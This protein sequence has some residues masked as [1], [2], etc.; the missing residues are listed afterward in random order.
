MHRRVRR[1]NRYTVH[2]Q[3]LTHTHTH[4]RT[5]VCTRKSFFLPQGFDIFGRLYKE[6]EGEG[7]IKHVYDTHFTIHAT[8]CTI[9]TT[10]FTLHHYTGVPGVQLSVQA[11]GHECEAA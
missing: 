11:G 4:R 5:R 8:H 9:H 2:A 1:K 6:K 3:T 10:Y 7:R